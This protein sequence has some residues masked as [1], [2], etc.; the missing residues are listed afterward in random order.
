MTLAEEERYN[1]TIPQSDLCH[2]LH[3]LTDLK[4]QCANEVS[5]RNE[6]FLYLSSQLPYN[7]KVLQVIKLQGEGFAFC[8]FL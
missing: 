8:F 6:C 4:Y 7:T 1:S 3:N 2:L 5:P